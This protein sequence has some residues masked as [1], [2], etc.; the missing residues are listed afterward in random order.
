[1]TARLIMDPQPTFLKPSDKIKTAVDYIMTNRY[2][3]LPVVD[4]EHRYLGI[5]GVNCLLRLV[6]PKA[7]MMERG[8]DNVG[9]IQDSLH[10]LHERLREVEDQPISLCMQDD[11][12]TVTP[13][14]PLVETLLLLYQH[15]ISIPVVEAGSHKLLGMISY[16]DVGERILAA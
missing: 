14:T 9:F 10:D 8:L 5:F 2:R 16:F 3:S 7:A 1:M 13:D 6:L 12:A 11:V 15:R 4:D